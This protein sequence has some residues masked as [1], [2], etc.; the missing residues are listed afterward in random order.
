MVFC[1]SCGELLVP[2][3]GCAACRD[4]LR[5]IRN[6][7][8]EREARPGRPILTLVQTFPRLSVVEPPPHAA[9]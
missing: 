6:S 3:L 9:A 7:A 4:V 5:V 1:F 8:T 2:G